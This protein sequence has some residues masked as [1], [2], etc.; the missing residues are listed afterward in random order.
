MNRASAG[1]AGALW[2]PAAK[3]PAALF[4]PATFAT[5]ESSPAYAASPDASAGPSTGAVPCT[6]TVVAAGTFEEKSARMMSPTWRLAAVFRST[7]SSGALKETCRKGIPSASSRAMAG[8]PASTGRRM[9]ADPMV[10]QAPD[11]AAGPERDRARPTVSALTRGPSSIST[12]GTTR[13]ALRTEKTVTAT[14]A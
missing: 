10:R 7:R 12:A 6:T 9:T 4:T 8:T 2:R 3:V 11:S 13:S 14:P 1:P 5:V